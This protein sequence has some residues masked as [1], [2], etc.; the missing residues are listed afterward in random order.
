MRCEHCGHEQDQGKICDNCGRFLTRVQL[1][2]APAGE[3]NQDEGPAWMT[4]RYCGH[5]QESGRFCDGCG[6]MLD[7]F[8]ASPTKE[9]TMYRCAQ[10][11]MSTSAYLCPNCGVPVPG[12]PGEEEEE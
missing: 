6:M 10:C 11:G 4:C 5:Q 8:R 1:D 3:G 2:S 12:H 7:D 9:T